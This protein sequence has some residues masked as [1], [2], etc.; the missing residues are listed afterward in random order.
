M[1]A[2]GQLASVFSGFVAGAVLGIQPQHC[3]PFCVGLSHVRKI[4]D[5]MCKVRA[6]TVPQEQSLFVA[7]VPILVAFKVELEE[8]FV[9]SVHHERERTTQACIFKVGDDCR[10]DILALQVHRLEMRYSL[11]D[12]MEIL[13]MSS[14][15]HIF[16]VGVDCRRK[17]PRPAGGRLALHCASTMSHAIVSSTVAGRRGAALAGRRR[18]EHPGAVTARV[19]K[20]STML[21]PGSAARL[22][23]LVGLL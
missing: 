23:V 15:S 13:T 8:R 9:D 17:H 10:Q 4:S 2:L 6:P 21:M 5:V 1:F 19:L 7:Q 16:K 14:H 3:K 22:G 12:R 18:M 20:R 11:W